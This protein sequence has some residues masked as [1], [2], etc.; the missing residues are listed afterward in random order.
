MFPQVLRH[1]VAAVAVKHA[2]KRR[3]GVVSV[4]EAGG[5]DGRHDGD[6]VLH[7]L[8]EVAFGGVGAKDDAEAGVGVRP[9]DGADGGGGLEQ[10]LRGRLGFVGREK[11]AHHRAAVGIRLAL[12]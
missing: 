5:A 6:P 1:F 3:L 2:T 7:R 8:P 11:A 12:A 4:Q 9:D 10:R